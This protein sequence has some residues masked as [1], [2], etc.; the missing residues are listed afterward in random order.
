MPFAQQ[1][2]CD[3]FW[4]LQGVPLLP[5][6]SGTNSLTLNGTFYFAECFNKKNQGK[7]LLSAFEDCVGASASEP[8]G[9][10]RQFSAAGLHGHYGIR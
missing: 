10:V 9:T 1:A 6:A 2:Q 8:Q 4:L 5:A 7:I 3:E